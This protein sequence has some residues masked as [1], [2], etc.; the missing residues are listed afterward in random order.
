MP[1]VMIYIRQTDYDKWL[2]IDN[3]SEWLHEHISKRGRPIYPV[4]DPHPGELH[5]LESSSTVE[6]DTVNV[7]VVGSTPTSPARNTQ[8]YCKN[9]HPLDDRGKC[10]GKGCK[11]S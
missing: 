2:A 11:Y 1:S 3:K 10:F 5:S 6:Q 4:D 7:K 8:R 9:G